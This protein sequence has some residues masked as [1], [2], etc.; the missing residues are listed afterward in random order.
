MITVLV[1][2]P[3]LNRQNDRAIA[4]DFS[5]ISEMFYDI[6]GLLR[7]YF[8]IAEDGSYGGGIY[9]WESREAAQSFHSENFSN[10][11]QERYGVAPKIVFLECPIVVDNQFNYEVQSTA[12]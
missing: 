3:L 12:A 8:I 2:F 4:R 11:I 1:T 6:P 9:L 7:K 5:N 10:I